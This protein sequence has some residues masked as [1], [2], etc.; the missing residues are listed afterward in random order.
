MNSGKSTSQG[1]RRRLALQAGLALALPAW[2]QTGAFPSRPLRLVVPF[3][4]GGGTDTLARTLGELLG[5]ELGQPVVIENKAGAGTV[6]GND[7]VAKSAPDGHTLLIN[8]NAF[9]IVPSLHPRLPYAA[10]SAFTAITL[11]GRAPNVAVV[12]ADSPILSGA[13]FLAQ[14]RARPGRLSYGSAGNGTSTHLSAELLKITARIFVTHV[15]Y[16]G[17]TPAITDLMG[18][19]IDLAFGTL[20]SVAP[21]LASGKLRALA[22]TSAARSPLLPGV[23]TFAESGAKGYDAD[24]W[25][26]LFVAAGTPAP[27]VQQ[28]HAAMQRVASHAEFRKRVQSEGLVLSLETPDD[29]QAT[30]RADVARWR[31]VVQA[32]SIKAD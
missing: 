15:P 28:L 1:V 32:Q 8:T 10:E 20:P 27:I 16:R 25:Y 18:G 5:R 2:A 26:G 3:P 14:A 6:I 7:A 13:D 21:F 31:R 9:A 23:P 19:Q 24:V 30:V 12:R 11:L 4:A 22:V 17:A 29:A